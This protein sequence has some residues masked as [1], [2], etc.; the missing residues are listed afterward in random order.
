LAGALFSIRAVEPMISSWD[1]A[2]LWILILTAR[3]KAYF[4]F[5][6]T[7]FGSPMSHYPGNQTTGTIKSCPKLKIISKLPCGSERVWMEYYKY[8]LS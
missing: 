5:I 3:S 6:Y 4:I 2:K 7:I 1:M 8:T